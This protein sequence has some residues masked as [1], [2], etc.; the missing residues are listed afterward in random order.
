MDSSSAMA[1]KLARSR[2]RRNKG[3]RINRKRK[4]GLKSSLGADGRMFRLRGRNVQHSR[5]V[6]WFVRVGGRPACNA[7]REDFNPLNRSQ[8]HNRYSGVYIFP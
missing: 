3:C 2:H 7:P 4:R 6:Q 8:S 5:A 1:Q